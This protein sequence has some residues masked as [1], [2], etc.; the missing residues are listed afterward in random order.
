MS[1]EVA[2]FCNAQ[3]AARLESAARKL[4]RFEQSEDGRWLYWCPDCEQRVELRITANG[5][6]RASTYGSKTCSTV[7]RIQQWLRDNGY[8]S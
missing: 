5:D 3:N 7:L 2:A 4:G 6:V 1:Q 8:Q